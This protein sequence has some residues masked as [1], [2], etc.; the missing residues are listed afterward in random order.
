ML[1]FFGLLARLFFW[2]IVKSKDLSI[3]AK[4]QYK[5]STF[6][7][8]PRGDI[9]ASD[10]SWLAATT[11][12]WLLYA[13][14][15]EIKE[16]ASV[17]ADKIGPILSKNENI[18]DKSEILKEV[19]RISGLLSKDK[20]VWIPIKHRL[21][22]ET[23]TEV[24]RLRIKGLGF[25]PEE[26]RY[27]PEAS[28]GAQLL[29]FVGKNDSGEDQ[30]YF[31]L[32]GYYDLLLSGKP[33]VISREEDVRGIPILLGGNS[34]EVPAVKG[35]NLVTHIDKTIEIILE[36]KLKAGI[37][38]YG[39][40]SGTGVVMDPKNGA[41]L[42]MSSFPSYNPARYFDYENKFFTNPVVSSTFEPGSVFKVIVMAS[43]LDAKVIKPETKCDI[44]SG[45]FN[46]DGYSIGTWN[47][48]YHP[49]ST[50][51]EVIV[52]SDNVGMAYVGSKLGSDRMF[53][54][55]QKFGIGKI[56]G[57]DLQGEASAKLREKGK[58][59]SVD[60]AT[61]SFGQ[62]VAV[63]PI[64][65]LR[66]VAVI[67]NKGIIVSP[68]VVDKMTSATWEDKLKPVIG[69]RVLSEKSASEMTAM[70]VEAAKHGE[71]K[72]T[73]ISGFKIAGKTG[74]AQ[75]PIKG[76][77][78][79]IK[80]IASF[81]GFAP[82]DDPKFVMLITLQQ[83]QTSPWASETAAPLWYSIARDLFNYF[84]IQPEQ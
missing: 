32:E 4:Q 35:V 66:A 77:Y 67:A 76:H 47:N 48:K 49:D 22:T 79:E 24:E 31:G 17:I 21:T 44:C 46:V 10:G 28:S 60:L 70:M 15:P 38:K 54:Y 68:Q 19:Y 25:D 3:M 82:Y 81:I 58:W 30:G 52:N 80:T 75:I 11:D 53:D 73:N 84:G 57:I 27:Y 1:A 61:A 8:A 62:G 56:T 78:D 55:L 5:G 7:K 18:T 83:P 63:T 37:E 42:A 33:G 12:A 50:M 26:I 43:A 14:L 40:V 23:K 36:N 13:S 39:A 71:S 65:L 41:V 6:I 20:A 45:P 72:W 16:N 29:G 9:L 64:Q 59:S 51:T 69:E 34:R 74:T 2:Q